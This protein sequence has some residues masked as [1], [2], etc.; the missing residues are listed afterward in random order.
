MNILSFFYELFANVLTELSTGVFLF[1]V[2]FLTSK[3]M[4]TRKKER[5]SK[6]FEESV[7]IAADIIFEA[8]NK[9]K[10]T[11]RGAE[12]LRYAVKRFVAE[13]GIDDYEK[14]QNYIVQIF[15]MTKLSDEEIPLKQSGH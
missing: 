8:E 9:F 14:A 2:G 12:K 15:N 7:N 5:E 10:G 11:N 4:S 6:L 3:V 13:T 1:C